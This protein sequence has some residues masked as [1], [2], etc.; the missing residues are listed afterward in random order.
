MSS[1]LHVVRAGAGPQVLLIHGS[2]ADHRTWSIQLASPL[3]ARFTLIAYDRRADAAS[4]EAHAD[5]AAALLAGAEPAVVVGSSFGAVVALEL[6]RRRHDRVAGAVLIEPPLHT[7]DDAP[8]VR[9]GFLDDFDRRAAEA[10]GPAAGEL[11]LRTV[12]GDGAFER[13]PRVF[14]AQAMAKFAEIRADS[15]ALFAYPPRLAELAATTAPVL[16]LGGERS[17]RCTV[18]CPA[19]GWRSSPAPATCS[20]PR[21]PA[22]STRC[23]PSSPPRCSARVRWGCN[24]AHGRPSSGLRSL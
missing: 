8:A 5:V 10:G 11:F 15:V 24:A 6:V 22:G 9:A 13:M 2:A 23:S 14:Q 1:G 17:A 18:R 3:R 12:L 21:R 7:S 20:T 19:R 16:L 4:V